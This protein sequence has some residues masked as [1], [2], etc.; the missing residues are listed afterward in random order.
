MQAQPTDSAARERMIP[1]SYISGGAACI[2][3]SAIAYVIA[4]HT[5][6][7]Q[8]APL[9]KLFSIGIWHDLSHWI[10]Y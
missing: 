5:L 3:D 6:K 1:W 8:H 2:N 4:V 9:F 10:I 7:I